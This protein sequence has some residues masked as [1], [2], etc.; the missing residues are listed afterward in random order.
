MCFEHQ[1]DFNYVE[2][3]HLWE[4]ARVDADGLHLAGMHY[5]VVL[6]EQEPDARAR[7]A[8]APLEQS[9]GVLRY[10]PAT[11]ERELIE[12]IDRRTARDVRVTPPTPGLRVRHVVKDA[13]QWLIVFNEVRT[14]AEFTL[15][16]AAL[17][18]GDA[19]RVNPATSDRRPLPPDRRLS[20]AGHEIT[21]IAMEP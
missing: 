15:E 20:L 3:Q 7:A 19:L 17:G 18:A 2:E 11:P 5:A 16:W 12:G 9:G 6:F 8:L 4:D 21:V 1:V 14:P 13:R 10:D